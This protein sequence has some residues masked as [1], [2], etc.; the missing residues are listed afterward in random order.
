[1]HSKNSR[2]TVDS[3]LAH[4]RIKYHFIANLHITETRSA[5]F[6][7]KYDEVISQDE[8]KKHTKNRFFG[9]R[10]EIKQ[11]IAKIEA[12]FWMYSMCIFFFS[13]QFAVNSFKS[14]KTSVQVSAV[15]HGTVSLSHLFVE[16]TVKQ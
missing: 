1:M 13:F 6:L 5:V 14:E 15:P 10:S 16:V 3:Q 12:D 11:T 9:K 2:D 8:Q 7:T 4:M